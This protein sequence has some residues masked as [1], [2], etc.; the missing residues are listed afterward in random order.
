MAQVVLGRGDF[1][2]HLSINLGFGIGVTLGIHAAG[3]IS[4]EQ[5]TQA[6]D[7]SM[8]HKGHMH[9]GQQQWAAEGWVM[10]WQG[11]AVTSP[12]NKAVLGSPG[13]RSRA[14]LVT[15]TRVSLVTQ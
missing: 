10:A 15:V 6:W 12:E 5:D 2:Q 7:I 13:K 1:G 14:G 11:G 4:G 3:G 9:W 8:S